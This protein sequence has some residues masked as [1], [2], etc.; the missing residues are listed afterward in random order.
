[1]GRDIPERLTRREREIMNAL[2]ASGNRASAEDI[3]VQLNTPPSYS[4]VRT[5]L[6]RLEEKGYVR[7]REDGP[8]YI[9]SASTSPAKA[10]RAALQHLVRTFFGGSLGQMMTSLLRRESW[11]VDELEALRAEIATA[12][13]RERSK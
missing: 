6:R 11:T 7:H 8:R 2:F 1:M 9:Y 13:Q 5:M 10:K 3:R 4:A 12:R